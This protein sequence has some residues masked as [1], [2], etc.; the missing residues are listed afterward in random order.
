[1]TISQTD[2]TTSLYLFLVVGGLITFFG[3]LIVYFN[4]KPKRRR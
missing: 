1:M 3:G 4:R 2:L